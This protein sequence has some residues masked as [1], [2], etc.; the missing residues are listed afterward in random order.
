MF[1][2]EIEAS[3][4]NCMERVLEGSNLKVDPRPIH[5][6]SHPIAFEITYKPTT[7]LE[8]GRTLV[9]VRKIPSPGHERRGWSDTVHFR[10]YDPAKEVV[11]SFKSKT[12]TYHGL[13]FERA[14]TDIVKGIV[15]KSVKK[16]RE[17]AFMECNKMKVCVIHDNIKEIG[18]G[19]FFQCESLK[20]T[21]QFPKKL[22]RL[23]EDA[24]MDCTSLDAVF[25]PPNIEIIDWETFSSCT[26][27]RVLSLPPNLTVRQIGKRAFLG[28]NALQ[29]F[30]NYDYDLREDNSEEIH[31]SILDFCRNQPPLHQVCLDTNVTAQT[32][33]ECVDEH[34]PAPAFTIDHNGM[35]PLH[36]LAINPY[37]TTGSILACL[38]LNIHAAVVRD[39][40][41]D[42]DN[43]TDNNDDDSGN[44]NADA[45]IGM[46]P[47]DYLWKYENIDSLICLVQALCLH[48]EGAREIESNLICLIL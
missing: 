14:P 37:A 1:L 44:T 43:E 10:V 45:E 48:R 26:R 29:R 13:E 24:F 21:N 42:F 19:A 5:Y 4:Y 27:L 36:I 33:H 38:D 28:C 17:N 3:W 35:T 12:Y 41:D 11:P 23:G 8:N 34:G 31:Q 39:R 20:T 2:L 15:D 16:I 47:L 18:N 40:V 32:I 7:H 22:R 30:L 6:M 25:I 9:S 46:T